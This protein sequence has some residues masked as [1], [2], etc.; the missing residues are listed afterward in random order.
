[1]CVFLLQRVKSSWDQTT[2]FANHVSSSLSSSQLK[3]H[4][5][6]EERDRVSAGFD[7]CF[8]L[9]RRYKKCLNSLYAKRANTFFSLC[10]EQLQGLNPMNTIRELLFSNLKSYIFISGAGVSHFKLTRKER[11]YVL[12]SLPHLG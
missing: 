6:R 5:H 1:M 8:V 12:S 4:V 9:K 10:L 3:P 2:W 7:L 11:E